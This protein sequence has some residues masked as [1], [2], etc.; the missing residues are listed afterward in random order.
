MGTKKRFFLTIQFFLTILTLKKSKLAMD[1]FGSV[2]LF[3][4][5]MAQ[6]TRDLTKERVTFV[7]CNHR[8]CVTLNHLV[9]AYYCL[10]YSSLEQ[11]N[12]L[13]VF[14]DSECSLSY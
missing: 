4:E 8:N 5:Q 9:K 1:T 14:V 3:L 12:P 2:K 11:M 6:W 10:P 13:M 7:A